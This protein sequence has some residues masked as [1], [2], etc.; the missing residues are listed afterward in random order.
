M[1]CGFNN[2]YNCIENSPT[3]LTSM[4]S[5]DFE[6][7]YLFNHLKF[8]D[9]TS[10]FLVNL[11]LRF[12][13]PVLNSKL[14]SVIL[15]KKKIK[16]Y[17]FGPKYNLTYKYTHLGT[18]TKTLLKF[19]EGRHYLA[20][21]FPLKYEKNPQLSLILY[22]HNIHKMYKN[23]VYKSMFNYLKKVHKYIHI[24]Y[25]AKNVSSINA[26][27]L[28]IQ[29]FKNKELNS[30]EEKNDTLYYYIGSND[31]IVD[32]KNDKKTLTIYQ[33]SHFPKEMINTVDVFL[34]SN[35][36]Q[37]IEKTYFINCF[38]LLQI[39]KRIILPLNNYAKNNTDII[40]YIKNLFLNEEK[41][42]FKKFLN[43]IMV[44]LIETF[45]ISIM[46][47]N[48]NIKI[49]N[50]IKKLKIRFKNLSFL[51]K[52]NKGNINSQALFLKINFCVNLLLK[53]Y[54]ILLNNIGVLLEYK[55]NYKFG[56]FKRNKQITKNSLSLRSN[57]SSYM[58]IHLYDIRRINFFEISLFYLTFHKD[59]IYFHLITN[60]DKNFYKDELITSYSK[61][62]N[63]LSYAFFRKK[64]NFKL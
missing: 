32:N 56:P 27:D 44:S 16:I 43:K 58:P 35:A 34:P 5:H 18:T 50:L 23:T 20:N 37:E 24:N 22:G 47:I 4:V 46:V 33:N 14:R 53:A 1:T 3:Y 12:E 45:K 48:I 57:L 13:N 28:G 41:I 62:M 52:K 51:I 63:C 17:Y 11:N 19:I 64:S 8:S 9:Y 29:S 15:W 61:N 7:N 40:M 10:F 42:K 39:S 49:T 2:I 6:I 26:Y 54:S 36:S 38:G 31:F 55:V 21:C 30:Y 59:F 60:E 25:L